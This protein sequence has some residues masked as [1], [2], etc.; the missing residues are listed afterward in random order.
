MRKCP[1][2]NNLA[3]EELKICPTCG[4]PFNGTEELVEEPDNTEVLE[5]LEENEKVE[6]F[7]EEE[8][9]NLKVDES[10][11]TQLKESFNEDDSQNKKVSEE[12]VMDYTEDVPDHSE[13]S[14]VKDST[15]PEEVETYQVV[16][17]PELEN[18][19]HKINLDKRTI[20]EIAGGVVLVA[21]LMC[22]LNF[23][24]K[25]HE[26][27][28]KYK[29]E[30]KKVETLNKTYDSLKSTNASL[31]STIAELNTKIEELENGAAKQL[32]DIKNAYEAGEWQKVIDLTAQLHA[33]YNGTPEDQEAQGMAQAS[34]DQLNQIAAQ[35]AAEE[36]QGYETGITYDQLARTPDQFIGKKVKFTGKVLQ[37]MENGGKVKI[38]LAVN[39]NYDTVIYGQY[40]SSI[41][42]SRVLEDDHITIY[43]ISAG[44][45][46]YEATSGAQIT[47]PGISI[48]KIDQ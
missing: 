35:K 39:D 40:D 22:A 36:A 11:L 46:S 3:E 10:D 25:Y 29:E 26:F 43:G 7:T 48:G 44:T 16:D 4:Y 13:E 47:I 41:V 9:A 42:S 21:S 1:E 17:A 27:E 8:E 32:V 33:K 5:S 45:I 23:N 6:D 28:N 12:Q 24:G 38:R 31:N 19:K 30:T 37:V 14:D 2:C 20:C 18:K 34:Q 15:I